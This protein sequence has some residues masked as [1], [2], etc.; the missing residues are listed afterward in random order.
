[1]TVVAMEGGGG[2][3]GGWDSSSYSV[4]ENINL[5]NSPFYFLI[6]VAYKCTLYSV[7]SNTITCIWC[8]TKNWEI[9]CQY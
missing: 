4:L 3:G 7:M 6:H 2:V 5:F 1:M 9:T 8:S